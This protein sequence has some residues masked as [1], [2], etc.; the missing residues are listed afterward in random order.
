MYLH[1]LSVDWR[2]VTIALYVCCCVVVVGVVLQTLS[3]TTMCGINIYG[4]L[5]CSRADN[6]GGT[7]G[8][9]TLEPSVVHMG[10][11]QNMDM[12]FNSIRS[13]A[14]RSV[15]KFG[16]VS[17]IL[18]IVLP[19][20]QLYEGPPVLK[21]MPITMASYHEGVTV[22]ST[23]LNVVGRKWTLYGGVLQC[24]Q[25]CFS[26]RASVLTLDHITFQPPATSGQALFTVQEENGWTLA[27]P[28]ALVAV[29]CN[30]PAPPTHRDYGTI[31]EVLRS[32]LYFISSYIGGDLATSIITAGKS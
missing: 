1:L 18:P 8:A 12:T 20:G 29:A 23:P 3:W 10:T 19:N 17:L 24:T 5:I 13:L 28:R 14:F 27:Q 6:V 22:L 25:R 4:S 32:S 31:A 26:V 15:A 11:F 9:I 7:L 21:A 16:F 30:F 2:C